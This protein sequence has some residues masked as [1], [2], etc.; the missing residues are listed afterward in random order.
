MDYRMNLELK[1]QAIQS[2]NVEAFDKMRREKQGGVQ[3]Q[4]A[5]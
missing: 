2:S 5:Y 3:V 4:K 1:N